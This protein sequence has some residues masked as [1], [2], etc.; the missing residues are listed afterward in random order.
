MAGALEWI[1]EIARWVGRLIPNWIVVD[2]THGGVKFVKGAEVI[3]FGPGIVWYWPATTN[4]RTYPTAR[5]AVDLR[6]QTL[7]TVDGKVIAVGGIVVYR[8]FDIA[9]LLGRTYDS[10]QTV[11]DICAGVIHDVCSAFSMEDMREE[12]FLREL[13]RTMQKRL[14]SYGVRVVRATITDLAPCRVLKVIQSTSSDV[15]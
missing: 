7:V 5:Q 12:P 4:L 9:A 1:S 10:D 3:P 15:G 11:K 13:K 2:A 14:R 8:V 6:T